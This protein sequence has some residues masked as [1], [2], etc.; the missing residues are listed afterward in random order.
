MASFYSCRWT[1]ILKYFSHLV[2]L[3]LDPI[4]EK[5]FG[6]PRQLTKLHLS[7]NVGYWSA[8]SSIFKSFTGFF[9]YQFPLLVKCEG[10]QSSPDN[11]HEFN[12]GPF[13]LV[14]IPQWTVALCHRDRKISIT[15][16]TQSTAESTDC[17]SKL[18]EPL[19]NQWITTEQFLNS[20]TSILMFPKKIVLIQIFFS[21]RP[22]QQRRESR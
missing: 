11:Q 15:A 10:F 17:C 13:T 20:F 18:Y 22:C 19:L 9:F 16:L 2:T 21:H 7:Y 8:Q 12:Y 3:V 5:H 1:Y 4:T 6:W 14:R